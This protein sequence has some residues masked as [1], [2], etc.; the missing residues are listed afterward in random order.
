MDKKMFVAFARISFALVGIRKKVSEFFCFVDQG[1][2]GSIHM[3]D[4]DA[5][6][7]YLGQPGLSAIER[8]TLRELNEVN[9]YGEFETCSLINFVIVSKVSSLTTA[10][11]RTVR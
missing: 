6:L 8:D 2:T 3:E 10:F 5:G 11:K 4:L 9:E 1:D 7:E